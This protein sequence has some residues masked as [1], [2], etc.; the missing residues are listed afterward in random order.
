MQEQGCMG[1]FC[2]KRTSCVRYVCPQSRQEPSERLCKGGAD[3][4][5]PLGKPVQ[6]AEPKR[7][8]VAA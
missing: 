5:W 1:G 6:I 7:D 4:Y 2:A 3:H 8:E